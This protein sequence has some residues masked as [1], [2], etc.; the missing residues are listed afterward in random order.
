MM[1]KKLAGE[2]LVTLA[3]QLNGMAG[4]LIVNTAFQLTRFDED[5]TS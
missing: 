5:C 2:L 3:V 4:E 1:R